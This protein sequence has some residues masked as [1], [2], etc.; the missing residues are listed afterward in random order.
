MNSATNV[1][2]PTIYQSIDQLGHQ[3][4]YNPSPSVNDIENPAALLRGWKV[5]QVVQGKMA[6]RVFHEHD[7]SSTKKSV[8]GEWMTVVRRKRVTARAV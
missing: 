5:W 8:C 6:K 7:S 1:R 4:T 2:T 3:P